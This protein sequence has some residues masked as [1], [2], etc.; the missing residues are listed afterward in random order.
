[1]TKAEREKLEHRVDSFISNTG[2]KSSIR[3]TLIT[4]H[5][6]HKNANSSIVQSEV[7]LGDLL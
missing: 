6:M 5:G 4:S 3:V 1:M 7:M 2:T